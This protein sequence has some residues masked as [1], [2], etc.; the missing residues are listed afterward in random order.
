MSP[1]ATNKQ[2]DTDASSGSDLGLTT[3][4]GDHATHHNEL[5]VGLNDLAFNVKEHGAVGDGVADDTTEVQ[6]AID[7]A[8]AAGG[9]VVFFP[10]GTYLCNGLECA[11][12]NVTL[13]GAGWGSILKQVA[14]V[15]DGTALL[16][17]EGTGTGT[18]TNRR[19]LCFYDLQFYGRM[20]TDAATQYV[21]L[22]ALSG[23]SH[24]WIERCLFK[25]W[26]GDGLYLAS[27][28]PTS[29]ERHNEHVRVLNCTFDGVT[30]TNRN[31]ISIIDGTNVHINN[32]TF[33]SCTATDRP[34]A[35][36]MEPN[37][38]VY[39]RI[40]D[41]EIVG[42]H[43]DDVGGNAGVVGFLCNVTQ[44]NLTN[45]SRSIIISRNTFKACTNT[46]GAIWL[47]HLQT[48]ADTTDRNDI[49]V[50]HNHVVGT[51]PLQMDGLR[52]VQVFGNHF[53]DSTQNVA[54]GW[55]QDLMDVDFDSNIL[56]RV[57]TTGGSALSMASITRARVR[58]NTFD[59]IG[60]QNGTDGKLV[61]FEYNSGNPSVSS[62]VEF[63]GNR[64]R[65][66]T[67]TAVSSKDASHTMSAATNRYENN[68]TLAL[69]P[70]AAHWALFST[71]ASA[72]TLTLPTVGE[73][74]SVTGSTTV[75]TITASWAGRRVVLVWAASATFDVTDG[76][77]LKLATSLTTAVAD[78]T[79]DL[80]C[81]G[82]NWYELGRSVN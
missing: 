44:A 38:E 45:K 16:R 79:L 42:N 17:S 23:V 51:R 27:G 8:I 35:I 6:A 76:S 7:G 78:S 13:Q 56:Y 62:N 12:S 67:T 65:G 77:N 69:T 21:H 63:V 33:V 14:G 34:G 22:L 24:V 32:N 19:G 54:F 28:F 57:G 31:G 43:F 81:D 46:A 52:G 60:L 26:R 36:D 55:E 75:T 11:G 18:S 50:S 1:L 72:G 39:A 4:V 29:Q 5:A 40:R 66:T 30:K 15:A 71:V 80:I 2:D 73:M 53:T 9:G 68:D 49:E 70:T 25:A 82:T 64:T 41:I 20:E 61:A 37:G 58:D 10:E 3:T 74:F 48:P 59:S 47:L